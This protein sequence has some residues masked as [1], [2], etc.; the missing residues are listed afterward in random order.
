MSADWSEQ[1]VEL[2]VADYLDMLCMELT[3]EGYVKADHWRALM[4][5]LSGRTKGSIEFKYGNV[6]AVLR[7]LGYP[8]VD[9]YKPYS[10]YQALVIEIVQKQLQVRPDLTALIERDVSLP[11]T[12]PTFDNILAA[13]VDRPK[14]PKSRG[15]R[16]DKP[17]AWYEKPRNSGVVN[18]LETEASNR[19]LGEAGEEFTMHFETARLVAAG[20]EALAAR[21][22]RISRTHGDA[23]GFDILSFETDGRERLVE[24]KT[25]RYGKFTPFFLSRNEVQTSDA[26]TKQYILYR[27]FQFRD[28]PKLFT[29]PGSVRQNCHLNA[30]LFEAVVA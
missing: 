7:D 28:K 19:S 23:A 13:L 6:S 21:V 9:G 11:A 30:T 14:A 4:P 12:I 10:N 24:V 5:R 20:R 1:E 29:L 22:E 2:A 17:V 3:H 15:R 16:T 8:F 25:T 27:L 26:Y 18:Y